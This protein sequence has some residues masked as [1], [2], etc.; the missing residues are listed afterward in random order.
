MKDNQQANAYNVNGIVCFYLHKPF[1]LNIWI[2][3]GKIIDEDEIETF[4]NAAT[5]DILRNSG[6]LRSLLFWFFLFSIIYTQLMSKSH[7]PTILKRNNDNVDNVIYTC[8]LLHKSLISVILVITRCYM[9]LKKRCKTTLTKN[10]SIMSV[11]WF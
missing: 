9:Y 6:K 5:L 7:F 3:Q 1:Q 2:T 4:Y 8:F 10:R 11:I